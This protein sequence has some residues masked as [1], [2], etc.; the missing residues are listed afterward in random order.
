MGLAL[1]VSYYTTQFSDNCHATVLLR[2]LLLLIEFRIYR[3]LLVG[4]HYNLK[5]AKTIHIYLS[6]ANIYMPYASEIFLE[7]EFMVTCIRE[8]L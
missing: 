2:C 8:N 7:S 4:Y 1:V 5:D 3:V 6:Y